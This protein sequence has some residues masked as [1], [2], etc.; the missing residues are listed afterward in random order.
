MIDV[1]SILNLFDLLAELLK[2]N[3]MR[4]RYMQA[5][6]ISYCRLRTGRKNIKNKIRSLLA[7]HIPMK[8]V[9]KQKRKRAQ[10]E[11][12]DQSRAR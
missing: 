9:A 12:A 8:S 3:I 6:I 5:A 2:I 7:L 1:K 4:M 10:V 11:T